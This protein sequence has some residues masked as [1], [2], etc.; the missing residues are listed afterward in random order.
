MNHQYR[1]K[2]VVIEAVQ[3]QSD[4]RDA[5]MAFPRWLADAIAS[6]AVDLDAKPGFAVIETI[7][8]T[9]TANDS[10]WIIKGV[11]G[12][13][14]PCKPDIFEATYVPA[15]AAAPDVADLAKAI[16]S[17]INASVGIEVWG[18]SDQNLAA[19]IV[20]EELAPLAAERDDA[21]EW[22]RKLQ[23][24]TQTLTCVY[25]G[26]EYPPGSPTHGSEVLTAHIKV[27]EKHPMRAVEAALAAMTR[28]ALR[29]GLALDAIAEEAKEH[30]EYNQQSGKT[31][32][33]AGYTKILNLACD[34]AELT[35]DSAAVDD[36]KC[37]GCGEPATRSDSEGV[38]LCKACYDAL[39]PLNPLLRLEKKK[40]GIW[41]H[42]R[43]TGGLGACINVTP[44][45]QDG[46]V[47]S[48]LERAI[49][50]GS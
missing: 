43:P 6:G 4:W 37:E 42:V 49:R 47:M 22:V 25:C 48:T 12:E 36:S 44:T 33:P 35:V 32:L 1:K 16:V 46:L 45:H 9:M 18:E 50:E 26:Q 5:T 3:F 29:R 7:D 2:P 20:R 34:A 8:G 14:Y 13:L 10:D 41:L 38:P 27:C 31:R 19:R 24:T 40:D 15:D 30:P 23:K 21:R 11:K 28:L 17:N 39:P